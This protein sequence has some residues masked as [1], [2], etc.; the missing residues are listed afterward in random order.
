MSTSS[1]NSWLRA[2]RKSDL[3]E[4]S[5]EIGFKKYVQSA[6][7]AQPPPQF[8]YARFL[9]IFFFCYRMPLLAS[10]VFLFCLSAS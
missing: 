4:L 10:N 3:V 1:A 9:L 7:G 5:N 8:V 2:Q 6:L